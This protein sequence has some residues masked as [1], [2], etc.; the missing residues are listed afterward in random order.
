MSPRERLQ[1]G[2]YMDLTSLGAEAAQIHSQEKRE[3]ISWRR[4]QRGRTQDVETQQ[5]DD[6][7]QEAT[8]GDPRQAAQAVTGSQPF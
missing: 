1:A 6:Q 5:R 2:T 3:Y 7:A 4:P 8:S